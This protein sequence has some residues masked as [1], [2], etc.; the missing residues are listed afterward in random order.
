MEGKT[1]EPIIKR[2]HDKINKI[3]IKPLNGES[4]KEII[5]DLK[6]LLLDLGRFNDT[7]RSFEWCAQH[8]DRYFQLLN[9]IKDTLTEKE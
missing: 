9:E 2:I 3:E 1:T 7:L 5:N 4:M 8:R 6:A